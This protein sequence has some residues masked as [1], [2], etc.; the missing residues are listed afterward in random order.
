MKCVLLISKSET[1]RTFRQC[2]IRHLRQRG[3]TVTVV[4][5]DKDYRRETR[6]L[7]A[8]FTCVRQENRWLN[9]FAICRYA[10][11]VGRILKAEKPDLVMTF[12]LKPNT[13]GVLAAA[14][15]GVRNIYTMIEGVGDV[16][17]HHTLK[18]K[19]IRLVSCALYRTSLRRARKVFFL[20][21]EDKQ[22]FVSRHLVAAEKCRVIPGIGVDLVH[23]APQPVE[24]SRHFLM[25]ARM[26]K[27][28]GVEDYCKCARLVRKKYPDA[29]FSYLGAEGTVRLSDIQPYIDEGSVRYLGTTRDVRPYLRDCTALLLP[30][31][32][33]GL[34][35]AVMEAAATG[36]CS[37][38]S[39]TIGCRDAVKDGETGFLVPVGDAKAMAEKCIY[40]IEHPEA[41]RTMG[42]A[43]RQYAQE[44]FDEK[45]IN[46]YLLQ[47]LEGEES[48]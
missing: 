47:E 48:L 23:F 10:W 30:S 15:A 12:Q 38:I 32:R 33:E 39:D 36:R 1:V 13:F 7:G 42:A 21:E 43:A 2:L 3:D 29:E 37:I 34:P 40:L 18:W 8:G 5:Y 16:F 19:L 27:T 4:A 41:A 22:E 45:T 24:N 17:L 44:K 46:S 31:Y 11:Q 25:V 28:K 6:A 26:L 14:A 9:P 35:M 20:N